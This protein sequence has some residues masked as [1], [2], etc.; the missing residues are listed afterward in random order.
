MAKWTKTIPETPGYSWHREDRDDSEPMI[1]R[2][3]HDGRVWNGGIESP[4]GRNNAA[5]DLMQSFFGEFWD[6][7]IS[8]PVDPAQDRLKK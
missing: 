5:T 8:A 7:P 4:V 2:L 3:D 6:E 1:L